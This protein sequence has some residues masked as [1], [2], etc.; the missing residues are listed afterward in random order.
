VAAAHP[1]AVQIGVD[2][3]KKGGSAVDAINAVNA[4]L[5]LPEP[6]SWH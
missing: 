6:M 1:L 2:I 3:L 4:A 5:G